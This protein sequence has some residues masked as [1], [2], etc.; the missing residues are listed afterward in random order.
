VLSAVSLPPRILVVSADQW[1]RALL[2]AELREAGYDAIGASTLLRALRHPSRDAARG[3]VRLLVVDSRAA[4]PEPAALEQARLRYPGVR[5]VVVHRAG[6][7]P[8]G[9]WAATLRRPVAIS[10]IVATV[11]R[12]VP[13]HTREQRQD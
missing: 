12:L 1:P 6:A 7:A 11:R 8:P 13:L 4:V 5:L 3:P 10:E 2:R 9:P